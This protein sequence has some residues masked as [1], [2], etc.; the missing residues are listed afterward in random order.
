M[1][2]KRDSEEHLPAGTVEGTGT[3]KWSWGHCYV[4]HQGTGRGERESLVPAGE[5][6]G[7][8][9]SAFFYSSVSARSCHG[10]GAQALSDGN[11]LNFTKSR[12][13]LMTLQRSNRLWGKGPL[14]ASIQE[15]WPWGED[16]SQPGSPVSRLW[17]QEEGVLLPL[18]TL[19]PQ[20]PV[21]PGRPCPLTSYLLWLLGPPCLPLTLICSH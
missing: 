21:A 18:L 1:S 9:I 17:R 8:E 4:N 16:G 19:S 6:W 15:E 13:D 14:P 12:E 2:E 7:E 11:D 20:L 3:G 5:G 10:T